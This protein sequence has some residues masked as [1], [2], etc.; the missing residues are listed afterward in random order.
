MD[1]LIDDLLKFSRMSRKSLEKEEIDMMN[2][3]EEVVSE[4]RSQV[5]DMHYRIEI[6]DLPP[7]KGDPA[8]IRQV[9]INLIS[10]AI[11]FGKKDTLNTITIYSD[12]ERDQV[13]YHIR[14][15]GIGFE[16]QYAEKIFEV[17]LQ[18]N[19][20]QTYGGT[21]VGLAIVKRII[22]RHG[23]RIR[24]QSEEGIGSTFSFTL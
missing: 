7:T 5:M 18:L 2:L 6:R 12:T 17:F 4:L 3:V 11:K 1:H 19:P 13:W 20:H 9:L 21:G 14:D 22:Y 10:N 15:S 23:G 24:V 16:M 8:L